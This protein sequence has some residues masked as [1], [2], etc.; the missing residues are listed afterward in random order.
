MPLKELIQSYEFETDSDLASC[1]KVEFLASALK[2]A[3]NVKTEQRTKVIDEIAKVL[4]CHQSDLN[5]L[6]EPTRQ[7]DDVAFPEYRP[8]LIAAE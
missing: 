8:C 7:S 6:F 3:K 4:G 1:V 2:A 5:F